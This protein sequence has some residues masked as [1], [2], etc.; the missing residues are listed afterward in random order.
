MIDFL[1]VAGTH[2]GRVAEYVDHLHE[3]FLDP[4]RVAGAAYMPPARPGF[5]V[6]MRPETL[7][8]FAFP[9]QGAPPRP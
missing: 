3:H 8:D 7:R 9:G 5:S 6:E 2:E 1:C 4:V